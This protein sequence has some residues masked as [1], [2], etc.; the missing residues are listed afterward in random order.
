MAKNHKAIQ[1]ENF[2]LERPRDSFV[3]C[4][5][6]KQLVFENIGDKMKNIL[7][8]AVG[9]AF[10]GMF[11]YLIS[12]FIKK[13]LVFDFPFATLVVNTLGC[14]LIGV[15]FSFLMRIPKFSE[16][17]NFLLV[18]G[19]CGGFTTFSTFSKETFFLLSKGKIIYA[20]LNI[21]LSVVLGICA[22]F[23]GIKIAKKC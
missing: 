4:D 3:V 20:I 12:G 18:T 9:S 23:I 10:G 8:V 11:R 21:L 5:N 15:L 1:S 13:I 2:S 19:F 16:E 22:T 14:F 7:F 6:I 17:L